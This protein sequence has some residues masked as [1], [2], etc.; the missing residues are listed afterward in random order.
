MGGG[1]G[2]TR[3][4][5]FRIGAGWSGGLRIAQGS[6]KNAKFRGN[7]LFASPPLPDSKMKVLAAYLLVALGGKTPVEADVKKVLS[8]VGVEADAA[9]RD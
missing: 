4:T 2:R 8:S 9:V 3:W 7:L 6:H 1:R 5:G